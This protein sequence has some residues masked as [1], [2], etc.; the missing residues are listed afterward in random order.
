MTGPVTPLRA[1]LGLADDQGTGGPI[2][3]DRC[4]DVILVASSR[5]QVRLTIVSMVASRHGL[6]LEDVMGGD[7][8]R[9]AVEA[10]QDAMLVLFERGD[11]L[12]QIGHFFGRDRDTVRHGIKRAFARRKASS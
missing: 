3:T 10:R 7:L 2:L 8:S 11:N 1:V 12:S 9:A 4:P 5:R 6:A